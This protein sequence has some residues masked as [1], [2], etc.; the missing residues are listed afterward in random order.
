MKKE[1]HDFADDAC[2]AICELPVVSREEAGPANHGLSGNK[3]GKAH[4]KG[5]IILPPL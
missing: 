1:T 4:P 2:G 5:I 3:K